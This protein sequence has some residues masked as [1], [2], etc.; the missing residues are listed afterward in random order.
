[1]EA[2][3][4]AHFRQNSRAILRR[5]RAGERFVLT[6]RGQTV[7]RL[8]PVRDERPDSNDPAYRLYEFA[9][10]TG[11]SLSNCE[12]DEVIYGAQDAS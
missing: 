12:L 1:M 2:I 4:M 3:S 5:L 10:A 11:G 9:D 8:E 6:W 7:A